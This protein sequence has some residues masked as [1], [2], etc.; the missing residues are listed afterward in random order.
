MA[1]KAYYSGTSM[2]NGR[3]QALTWV[4]VVYVQ[5]RLIFVPNPQVYDEFHALM[6]A[7]KDGS[8]DVHTVIQRV[9]HLLR[10]HDFLLQVSSPP[11]APP[12]PPPPRS[13]RSDACLLIPTH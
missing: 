1:D 4:S 2:R 3:P 11:H 9:R 13:V 5:V 12:R 7:F 6:L 8:M 10:D